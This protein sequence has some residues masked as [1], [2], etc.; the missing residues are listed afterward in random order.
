MLIK[1]VLS[2]KKKTEGKQRVF[3]VWLQGESD[4][5]TGTTAKDYYA[6]L[7]SLKNALK[8]DVKIEKFGIIKVGYFFCVARWLNHVPF[9][10]RKQRDEAIMG[11]QEEAVKTD[12][13]FVMLTRITSELSMDKQYISC[14]CDG[15]YN[16]KAMKIIGKEAGLKLSNI[17]NET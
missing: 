4:S 12:K 17:A 16:N 11:A 14:E 13:D 2:A 3:F 10:E 1:K 5:I 7:I 8:E 6:K 15:H 9:E